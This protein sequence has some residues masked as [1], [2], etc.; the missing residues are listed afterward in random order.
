[1][2]LKDSIRHTLGNTLIKLLPK[3]SHQLA[4]NGMTIIPAN[5]FNKTDVLIRNALLKNAELNNEHQTLGSYQEAYWKK[6][7]H[8]FFKKFENRFEEIFL[9][10]YAFIFNLL[11]QR[12]KKNR[13]SHLSLVEIGTGNGKVLEYL[14]NRF[15]QISSFIGIDLSKEQVA[16]NKQRYQAE[17]QMK[18]VAQDGLEWM[19]KN[20]RNHLIIVTSGGVLEY[21]TPSK[22][23]RLLEHL[24]NF[25]D[26]LFVAIE[27][28]GP[29]HNFKKNPNTELYGPERSFSHNYPVLFQNAGFVLWH[30]SYKI[31]T[32][33]NY[34]FCFI[35]AQ[36]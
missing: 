36:R 21:F 20:A 5:E 22:L 13:T 31:S 11:E 28:K 1:M 25:Q 32:L 34:H 16:E 7:G 30:E 18:F 2:N 27:P 4:E 29:H 12:L 19:M 14:K 10:E 8:F 6:R 3:R 26:I 9:K 23:K 15:P 17:K 35:G 33:S 24:S